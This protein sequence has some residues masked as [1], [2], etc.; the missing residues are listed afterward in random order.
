MAQLGFSSLG[1]FIQLLLNVG[2]GV[3]IIFDV[4]F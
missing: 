1:K 3:I 2:N 4:I